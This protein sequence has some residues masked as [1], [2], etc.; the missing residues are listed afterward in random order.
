MQS[1]AA[2]RDVRPGRADLG[3]GPDRAMD[4]DDGITSAVPALDR[5]RVSR[6]DHDELSLIHI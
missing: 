5:L 4:T 6:R 1:N 2:V 3:I